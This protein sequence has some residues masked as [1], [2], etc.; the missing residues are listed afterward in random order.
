MKVAFALGSGAARALAQI[1]VLKFFKEVGFKPDIITGSSIGAFLGALYAT[2][3]TVEEMQEIAGELNWRKLGGYLDISHHHGLIEGQ[4]FEDFLSHLISIDTF[5]ECPVKFGVVS[6]NF[7]TGKKVYH[8]SG[9]IIPAIH[10]SMAFPGVFS[11]VVTGKDILIDG[12]LVEPIPYGLAQSL[13]AD[14]IVGVN[15]TPHVSHDFKK[16]PSSKPYF[17]RPPQST[18]TASLMEEWL[19]KFKTSKSQLQTE[20][21]FEVFYKSLII[22]QNSLSEAAY[23]Q[24]K[25]MAFQ[26][27][28]VLSGVKVFDFYRA[29]DIMEK[30]YQAASKNW[31]EI[32][33]LYNSILQEEPKHESK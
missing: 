14:F 27:R 22:L 3:L 8:S 30:G 33:A 21:V 25:H 32:K 20:N 9:S 29:K 2:G 7:T 11:P 6:S 15:V 28:P 17:H 19:M 1:G 26:I 23:S 16:I 18:I 5:E 12:G 10:A 31:K 13:G 24:F 4:K